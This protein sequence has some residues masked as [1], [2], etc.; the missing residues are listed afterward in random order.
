M[1][2][3]LGANLEPRLPSLQSATDA[4]SVDLG[5]VRVSGV[6]ETEPVGFAPQPRFL[7][8]CLAG[9]TR[10]GPAALL[11]RLQAIER[12]AG[13]R[14][15]GPR[16]GPRELDLDLLLY[17]DR[18]LT[19]AP[20]IVPHPRLHERAFVL[21][22]LAEIV[23]GWVHPILDLTIGELAERVGGAGVQATNLHLRGER[24]RTVSERGRPG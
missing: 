24:L 14:P 12:E 3:G 8:A 2:I 23:P 18:I 15:G 4:L 20:P 16:N 22:P 13:R 21:V 7:N 17:G 5:A 10:M 6:Y 1:A 9:E 11:A 19:G